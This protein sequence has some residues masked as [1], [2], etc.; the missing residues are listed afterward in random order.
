MRSAKATLRK[1]GIPFGLGLSDIRSDPMRQLLTLLLFLLHTTQ[2]LAQGSATGRND[3]DRN[4]NDRWNNPRTA[5]LGIG[6]EIGVPRGSFN[7]SWGREIAGF[8]ANFTAP[9]RLLPFDW[10][11]DY[12]FGALGGESTVVAI[13]E[14]ALT[15]TTGDLRIRSSVMGYHGQLRLK[16]FNGKVAPYVE[17]LAG[18]RHFVTRTTIEVDGLDQPLR[19]DRNESALAWSSGWALGLQVAPARAFYVEGRVE[20]LNGSKVDYVDPRSI[21]IDPN[22]EVTYS[23]LRSGTHV[24]NI[25]L[26]VGLR[27]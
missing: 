27:F 20:R 18:A 1:F 11:F 22:G 10:G 2:L 3:R 21:I 7:D 16:P 17:V 26:G 15:A 25:H 12:S 13:D 24:M 9:M 4:N 23:T 14:E 6:L 5:T 8:S 19:K